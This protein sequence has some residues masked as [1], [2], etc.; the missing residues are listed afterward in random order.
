[1]ANIQ[2]DKDCDLDTIKHSGIIKDINSKQYYISII[3]Q[4]A[5]AA[6]HAK[7]VCNVSELQQEIVEVPREQTDNYKI[8]DKVEILMEKSLGPKAVML[9]YFFPF[10]LLLVTLIITLSFMKNQGIAG[11]IS[12]AILV[13]YYFILYT[14]RERLKNK[15]KFR[16]H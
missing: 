11:L 12:I 4:S 14:L 10:L 8:G 15:F 5:C 6:C 13:P 9:G 3:A 2:I 1:M 7:G 16:I